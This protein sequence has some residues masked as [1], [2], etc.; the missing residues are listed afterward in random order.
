[1]YEQNNND[2][3]TGYDQ[4]NNDTYSGAPVEN[5]WER[6]LPPSGN[7]GSA[8]GTSPGIRRGQLHERWVSRNNGE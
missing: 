5:P 7:S 8:P 6:P 4:N 3:Y 2:N 1:G